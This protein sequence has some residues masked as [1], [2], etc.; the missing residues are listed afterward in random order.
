MVLLKV[1]PHDILVGHQSVEN[2]GKSMVEILDFDDICAKETGA[3]VFKIQVADTGVTVGGTPHQ[4]IHD[5]WMEFVH[6]VNAII[7]HNRNSR[8]LAAE[9]TVG[10]MDSEILLV[11]VEQHDTFLHLAFVSIFLE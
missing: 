5:E 11:V 4:G 8:I 7:I 1:L 3:M 9:V 2:T 6:F 10:E